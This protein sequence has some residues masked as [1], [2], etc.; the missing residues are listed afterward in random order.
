MSSGSHA[1]KKQRRRPTRLAIV[2][3]ALSFVLAVSVMV[4]LFTGAVI[5]LRRVAPDLAEWPFRI[6]GLPWAVLAIILTFVF[7]KLFEWMTGASLRS[8]ST[9]TPAAESVAPSAE[10][11]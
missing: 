8:A 6:G 2:V 11:D 9:R 1:K 10:T 7:I 5:V 4:M 3:G